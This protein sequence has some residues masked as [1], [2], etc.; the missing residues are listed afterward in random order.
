MPPSWQ[1][2]ATSV[3]D[4]DSRPGQERP[5]QVASCWAW[6]SGPREP[7][8]GALA[9][10]AR[11]A[12]PAPVRQEPLVEVVDSLRRPTRCR[13]A[14]RRRG[15]PRAEAVRP[16]PPSGSRRRSASGGPG[17]LAGLAGLDSVQGRAGRVQHRQPAGHRL[18]HRE[19][20]GLLHRGGDVEVEGGQHRGRVGLVAAEDHVIGHAEPRYRGLQPGLVLAAADHQDL[21][22]LAQQRH[23]GLDHQVDA[24]VGV[25][26]AE[27]ADHVRVG[28]DAELLA[29]PPARRGV[30]GERRRCPARWG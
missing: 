10:A 22:P 17:H 3:D 2:A 9:A 14:R 24:L 28:R 8:A 25:E 23:G 16:P 26:P 19:P 7:A 12:A 6:A 13:N 18:E 29:D 20:E 4:L 1:A 30:E 11:R 27:R 21:A 15:R 5:G